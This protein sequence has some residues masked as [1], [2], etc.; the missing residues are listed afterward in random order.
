MENGCL[1]VTNGIDVPSPS[2]SEFEVSVDAQ[3]YTVTG[4]ATFHS[5][6][7]ITGIDS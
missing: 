6:G 5:F 3:W 4:V 2:S 1:Y 7:F